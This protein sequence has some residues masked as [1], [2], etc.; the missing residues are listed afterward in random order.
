[1]D[2]IQ[3][4]I[5]RLEA[6][7]K[8][9]ENQLRQVR[10]ALRALREGHTPERKMTVKAGLLVLL[11]VENGQWRRDLPQKLALVGAP[12]T[13]NTLQFVISTN[14]NKFKRRGGRVYLR[15]TEP[16]S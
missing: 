12:C 3:E 4:N 15:G 8:E 14:K 5:G 6:Q 11:K 13:A 7:A 16:K 10:G 9:L 2:F 1:M